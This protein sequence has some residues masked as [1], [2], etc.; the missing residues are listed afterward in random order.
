MKK[1]LA[2]ICA[3][4]LDNFLAWTD[5]IDTHE[6]RRFIISSQDELTIALEWG[7]L[8]FLE[9]CNELAIAAT[10]LFAKQ[11]RTKTV[12][13]RL[14]SYEAFTDMPEQIVWNVV[15]RLAFVADHVRDITMLYHGDAVKNVEQLVIPNGID[16]ETIPFLNPDPGYDIAVVGS[17][18]Y[19]KEPPLVL[20]VLK[21]LVDDYEKYH[22]HWAGAFQDARYDIY[23]QHM[24][25]EMGLEKNITFYGH[26]S[27][28][29]S[30]W[31]GK[32]YLLHTSVHEGH[33]YAIMEAMAR[34]ISPVIHN[35]YGARQQYP[36]PLLF[37]TVA[38]AA[39]KIR[40]NPQ[41]K[42]YRDH[43][44]AS[45]WTLDRQV[46]HIQDMLGGL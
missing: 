6:V 22:L 40:M 13:I 37:N 42:Q 4:G 7:D 29:D 41:G 10:R 2:V 45:G 17:I 36:E 14:H 12:I 8:I 31:R 20:Q 9:W 1:K 34:G 26:V 18:N 24:V 23:L 16:I 39:A 28:M 38:E 44:I 35:Y 32:H 21:E 25:K 11:M 19:K 27:D 30:F 3:A 5:R 46:T 15:D 33:S 43:V